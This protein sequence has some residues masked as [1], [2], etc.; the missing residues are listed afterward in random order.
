MAVGGAEHQLLEKAL[1][2]KERPVAPSIPGAYRLEREIAKAIDY[3]RGVAAVSPDSTLPAE[4][5]NFLRAAALLLPGKAIP[6]DT[7]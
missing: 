6:K 5:R 3:A 1:L 7:K 4:L 2:D